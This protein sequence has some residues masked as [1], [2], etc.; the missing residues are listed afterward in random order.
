MG[1]FDWISGKGTQDSNQKTVG[2]RTSE[3]ECPKCHAK[4]LDDEPGPIKCFSCGTPIRAAS[5][6]VSRGVE[7]SQ[8]ASLMPRASELPL[9][10][11]EEEYVRKC[12]APSFSEAQKERAFQDIPEL[13]RVL[14]PLNASRNEE[15][16]REAET[17]ATQY[18]DWDMS[19][20]WGATANLRLGHYDRARS[21]LR[22]GL[23]KAKRK[24]RLCTVMGE[25]EWK[26][27]SIK[28]ALFWLVQGIHCQE[29]L[30]DF[31]ESPYLYLHYIAE[32]L[33]LPNV[34]AA[35]ISRVDKIRYGG[36]RL[37]TTSHRALAIGASI[38]ELSYLLTRTSISPR[39]D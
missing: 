3:I 23:E 19:Y 14:G 4:M 6:P 35:F 26:T 17:L 38:D 12:L 28:D 7:N 1:V 8:M 33:E 11:S 2:P 27:K 34:A 32:G 9:V 25:V 18:S 13:Q 36:I 39:F 20:D 37:N 30:K 16:A 21:L 24:G 5:I 22:E 10:P 15:A 31:E 29:V